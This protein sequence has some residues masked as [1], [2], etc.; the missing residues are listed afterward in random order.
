MNYK[1]LSK[2]SKQFIAMTG[3]TLEEF[4]NLL[5]YFKLRF[6]VSNVRY[7]FCI[8]KGCNR[9]YPKLKSN[10]SIISIKY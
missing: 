6:D 5:S 7:D 2:N 4:K 1:Q 9:S 10:N 8:M 3:Y